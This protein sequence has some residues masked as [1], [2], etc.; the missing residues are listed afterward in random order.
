MPPKLLR[1]V[2]S[3]TNHRR[4]RCFQRRYMSYTPQTSNGVDNITYS[5]TTR[6]INITETW[7]L[8]DSQSTIDVFAN[9]NLLKNIRK[10]EKPMIIH[11]TAGVVQTHLIGTLPGYGTVWYH[12]TG[13]ANILSLARVREAGYIVT[14][15]SKDGNVFTVTKPDGIARVFKQSEKGLFYLDTRLD[16]NV[17]ATFVTTVANK[18]Y[19]YS[20][21]DHSQ[22]VLARKDQR[23]IGRPSTPQF[24]SILRNNL[25]LNCPIRA[26][27][28]MAAYITEIP[29]HIFERYQNVIVAVDIMYINRTTFLVTI[30]R[31]IHFATS[32]MINDLRHTTIMKAIQQVLNV[33]RVRNFKVT[34]LLADGQF[35]TMSNQIASERHIRTVK[36]RVRSIYNTLPFKSISKRM[37]IE[38]IYNCTFWLNSFPN[39]LG[40]STTISPRTIITGYKKI[41]YNKHC[42]LEYVEYVHTHEEHDNSLAS[43]T[44]GALAMRPT[45]NFQGSFVF[46]N[47]RTGRTIIRNQW[48]CIPM[49][50]DVIDRVHALSRHDMTFN[51]DLPE[52]DEDTDQKLLHLAVANDHHDDMNVEECWNDDNNEVDADESEGSEH[53]AYEEEVR[54][55]ADHDR[56]LRDEN[57]GNIEQ[58]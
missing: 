34:H 48:T 49:P 11:C 15:S 33:Y 29:P 41:D 37:L 1:R 16:R 55:G 25:L 12:P 45:G 8:L 24:L 4:N 10:S 39:A 54:D 14:Y 42:R 28:A 40:I 21:R 18:E 20:H 53:E 9:R 43:R 50:N 31:N 2:S 47:L 23:I 26:H 30:S 46:Y 57:I 56:D 38:L 19:K 5:M 32:E 36:E 51:D 58:I 6:N 7:I 17:D 22:A 35:E 13:I 27:D 3:D 44:V 52:E